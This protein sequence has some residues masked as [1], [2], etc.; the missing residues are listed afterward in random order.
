MVSHDFYLTANCADYV[1]LVEDN[2]IRKMRTRKF[3]KM[4]YDKYFD[5]K[6]LEIDK[7]KQQLETE[8]TEA[9]KEDDLM[10]VDKLCGQL[11]ELS[12]K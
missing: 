11:E 4:V 12:V 5:Q 10:Q 8:I 1:L 3:R 2:T 6:Y 9:F 7:Q